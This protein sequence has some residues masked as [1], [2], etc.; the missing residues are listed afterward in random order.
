MR[1]NLRL[2]S[3][4]EGLSNLI[5]IFEKNYIKFEKLFPV[6]KEDNYFKYFLP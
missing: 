5:N 6:L 1:N 4:E 2:R 3:K